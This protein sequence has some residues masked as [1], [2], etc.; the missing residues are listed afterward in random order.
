MN[1]Q[2]RLAWVVVAIN[3]AVIAWGAKT[4]RPWTV[5]VGALLAMPVLWINVFAML[6][7]VVPLLRE[8]GPVPARRWLV[9]P[10][11]FGRPLAA[12]R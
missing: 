9:Q 3:L 8:A 7:A 4:D 10:G 6:V 12:D 11:G 1:R 5:P 2:A